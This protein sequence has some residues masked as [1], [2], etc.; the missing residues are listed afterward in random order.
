MQQANIE[1]K[2]YLANNDSYHA[3]KISQDL[4]QI[5][6]IGTHVASR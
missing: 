2:Q 3:L 4:L 6:A 1:P 5:G